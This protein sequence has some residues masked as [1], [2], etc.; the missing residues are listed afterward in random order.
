MQREKIRCGSP[1]VS[2]SSF[3]LYFSVF[4]VTLWL[5]L[6]LSCPEESLWGEVGPRQDIGPDEERM[7]KGASAA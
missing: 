6:F 7:L 1:P 4:S 2:Y 5:T 3:L